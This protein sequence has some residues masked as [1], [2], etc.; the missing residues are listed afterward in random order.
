MSRPRA[1]Y[2]LAGAVSLLLIALSLQQ[3]VPLGLSPWEAVAVV[4]YA[5]STWL[6]AKNRPL[7]WWVGLVGVVAYVA[8]FYRVRLFA[9]VG[10]QAFYF[11]TSLQAIYV[12]LRGGAGK[13]ERPVGRIP[14]VMA[15]RSDEQPN[16]AIVW[17]AR[18][19]ERVI[20]SGAV[21][22]KKLTTR[23]NC[24]S[25]SMIAFSNS[26]RKTSRRTRTARSASWKT[27]A[28]AGVSATRRSRTS[29][30]FCR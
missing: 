17:R 26:F 4:S 30:S 20:S 28:G 7:G 11:V 1:A 6:L 9:E 23:S 27:I 29:N 19:G 8:V 25:E 21:R 15:G 3:H 22:W 13:T 12:W 10:I 14:G 18:E 24:F 5:W 16:Q 2:V